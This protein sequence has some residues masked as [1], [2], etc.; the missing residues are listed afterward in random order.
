VYKDRIKID[1]CPCEEP[2]PPVEEDDC[3]V[4]P[5]TDGNILG[6]DDDEEEVEEEELPEILPATGASS[7][8]AVWIP[9][10]GAIA[11]YLVAYKINNRKKYEA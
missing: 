4:I 8:A 10:A 1:E 11:T 7:S 5:P 2:E 6:E 3:P 9:L